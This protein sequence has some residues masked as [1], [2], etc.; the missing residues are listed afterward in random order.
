[1]RALL[2]CSAGCGLANYIHNSDKFGHGDVQLRTKIHINANACTP[3][4]ACRLMNS[5][6]HTHMH[7]CICTPVLMWIQCWNTFGRNTFGSIT[8][9]QSGW[10]PIEGNPVEEGVVRVIKKVGGG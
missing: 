1:M 4:C 2:H 10:F 5:Y 7:P 8:F 6:A 3:T 9:T